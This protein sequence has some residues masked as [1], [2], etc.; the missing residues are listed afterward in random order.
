MKAISN[1]HT[2][3]W[4]ALKTLVTYESVARL[5]RA[6]LWNSLYNI[7]AVLGLRPNFWISQFCNTKIPFNLCHFKYR[8]ATKLLKV[9]QI[10]VIGIVN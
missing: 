7:R 4:E 9:P 5:L 10:I 2:K 6:A 8:M 3:K 1:F